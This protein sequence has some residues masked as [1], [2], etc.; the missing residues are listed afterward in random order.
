MTDTAANN[1]RI[2]KNTL[3]LYIRMLLVIGITLFTSRVIIQ[4][5]GVID[6]GVYS[7]TTGVIGLLAFITISLSNASSRFLNFTIAEHNAKDLQNT[8]C[9][10]LLVQCFFIIIILILAETTGLWLVQ[11]KLVIPEERQYAALWAYQSAILISLISLLSIPYNALI[12]AYERMSVFAYISIIEATTKL[13]IAYIISIGGF[14]KLIFYSVLL[15][16][17]QLLIFLIYYFYCRNKF[18]NIKF[19][20]SFDKNLTQRILS[21]SFWAMGGNIALICCSQGLNILLNIFFGPIVNTAKGIATQIQNGITQFFSSF[22]TSINPQITQNYA[23]DNLATMHNLIING[24]KYSFFLSLFICMPLLF[25]TKEILQIWLGIVPEYTVEFA[26][27]IIFICFNYAIGGP[28]ITAIRATGNIR[29]FELTVSTTLLAILPICYISLKLFD[30]TPI[31]VFLIYCTI[32]YIAQFIRVYLT[33]PQINLPIKCYYTKILYPI[34]K[35]SS[36]V[37]I[38]PYFALSFLG[39]N[40]LANL[41]IMVSICTISSIISIYTIGMNNQERIFIKSK[42]KRLLYKQHT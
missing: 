39:N 41:A 27:I 24:A 29:K 5:L 26:R 30:I 40:I 33:F 34:I 17:N 35:V 7:V 23:S 15:I 13:T 3:I 25:Q 2:A 1:R 4:Q 36:I 38:L 14:D 12:I 9:S 22:Q 11:N 6:Y 20:F 28:I 37:W 8:F 42:I 31:D 16:L 32:E 18:P 19:K 10:I 21:F